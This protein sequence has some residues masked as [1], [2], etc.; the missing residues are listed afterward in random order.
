MKTKFEKYIILIVMVFAINATIKADPQL[1]VTPATYTFDDTY[2]GQTT[3]A[4]FTFAN[5]GTEAVVVSDI[6]FT[7]P[8]FS[9]QYTAFTIDPGESGDLPVNFTPPSVGY[10][11]GTMQIFSNDPVN[12]PYEVELSGAGTVQLNQGWQ[13]IQTPFDYILT[14]IEFPEGQNQVGYCVGQANTYNGE[15]II[16]KTTDGGDTWV[17]MT[18]AGTLWLNGLSFPEINI[19]YASGWGGSILKTTDGGN[20]W[21]SIVVQSDIY[22]INDVEFRDADHG[23]VTT[24]GNGVFVTS[25]GGQ[26]WTLASGVDVE[27]HNIA[28]ADDTT[29]FGVGNEDRIIRSTDGGY[30][31]TQLYTTGI[32]D[33][34]LLGVYFLNSQYGMAAGDYGHIYKT[35][36]GGDNWTMTIP[37]GDDLLH[38]PYIWDEDTAWVV[39]TPEFV[40]KTTNG[41]NSW[42]TAFNPVST[43][44]FYRV[45]FTDNYTGFIC[46]SHGVVLRKAGFEGP[47][48]EVSPNP[49]EFEDTYIGETSTAMVTFA[50]TG[51]E[52]LVVT[53]ITFTDPSFSIDYTSFSIDPGESGELPVKFTPDG[54]GLI[55]GVMQIH[56][57]NSMGDPYDVQLTGTG[58]VFLNQGWQWIQTPFDYILTDME[59]PEGQNQVGY[60]VGQANTYNGEGIVIKTTDGGDTWEQMTPAGTLWLTG[61]SFIDVNTGYV[62]GWGGDLLKTTD[63]GVTWESVTVQSNIFKIIDVE[64]RDM[65]NGVVTTIGDG[66]YVTDDGGQSWTLASGITVEP[67][68]IDYADDNTL[69]GVGGEDRIV[70]S[71]DGGYTWTQLYT[72]GMPE[73]IL[74]GVYFLNSQYGM[75]AG[76]Y[77]HIYTTTDGGDNWTLTIPAGD[78]LLHT[79]FIWDQD[80][81]WVVGTPEYVYKSTDGGNS[82]SPAY[83]G[84]YERAFY[85]ILFTDNYTGFICGSHGVV[86]RKEG[87]PA[88]PAINVSPVALDF[89]E[90]NTGDSASLTLTVSNTGYGDLLVT[91]VVSTNDAFS[92]DLTSFLLNPGESQNV[93]VTFTPELQAPYFG[94]IKIMSNDPENNMIEINVT[95]TGVTGVIAVNADQI[96]F[97]TTFVD[98]TSTEILTISNEGQGTLSVLNITSSNTAFTV[99]NTN[100]NLMP[101][102]EADVEVTFAPTEVMLY[103]GVLTIESNDPLNGTIEVEL[104]GYG[105]LSTGMDEFTGDNPV[106]VYPNPASDVL[107]LTNAKG[108]DIVIYNLLGGMMISTKASSDIEKINVSNLKNGIYIMKITGS[109]G[110]ISTKIKVRK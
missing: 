89:G 31:W 25:D 87:Y 101:G 2:V 102:M 33:N 40:Y 13:W 32:A 24:I 23:V 7:D 53:D 1:V 19:G 55:E 60:C 64:F 30:S 57:N 51:N 80:T 105:D 27:P 82:W 106:T 54:E 44:A 15:G 104:S 36:D 93:T 72:T 63:G 52:T 99:N 81:A 3:S 91:D 74:L 100:F 41:G 107:Y 35:T 45:T 67:K 83:N 97:D 11:T 8:A 66:V 69:F 6:T 62:C 79:P 47:I 71:T 39:G 110:I 56:S 37:A 73:N 20:N 109:S 12:N 78:D 17:Q 28:Y 18:P 90:V 95:G 49:V 26:T 4:M 88:I 96:V 48:L 5:T 22:K 85:R 42:N 10:F 108:K 29:V 61:I 59:F 9:I 14:D 98:E 38:I 65:D 50:N 46:G 86:L 68:M 92:V 21:E 77:G 34:I 70:R 58:L 84:N 76:D 16:I 75:A 94:L 103:E 43:R